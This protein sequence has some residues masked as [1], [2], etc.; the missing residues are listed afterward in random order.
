MIAGAS[1]IWTGILSSLKNDG[2]MVRSIPLACQNHPSVV[3]NAKSYQDFERTPNGGCMLKCGTRLDC[4]HA[5]DRKC[6]PV[7]PE[8]K[9]YVCMKPCVRIV[10]SSQHQCT[11]RCHEPCGNCEVVV[12]RTLPKCGHMKM[13][14]CYIPADE[15]SCTEPCP[16]LFEPCGHSC[17]K[18]CSE[19]CDKC[20]I[21]V[22]KVIP[23]CQH[24]CEIPCHLSPREFICRLP[25]KKAIGNCEH[26]CR[27]KC[28]EPCEEKCMALVPD[29]PWPCGHL[30]TKP[31]WNNP[32]NF[33]C[34][35][36]V[37]KTLSCG[38]SATLR[39]SDKPS[40]FQCR[41]AVC[42]RAIYVNIG[43]VCAPW[44]GCGL[45]SANLRVSIPYT[46]SRR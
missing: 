36:L 39:C 22:S 6:H 17:P 5:C 4:G 14:K 1:G 8:H 44:C 45:R 19:K 28:G 38:H 12:A 34:G 18:K 40:S 24:E 42:P 3:T 10:C 23:R 25:C 46:G 21:L 27:N 15:I 37:Q 13:T 32:S 7:D 9:N 30:L 20:E 43:N 2:K 35:E 41:T 11:K 31:C 33:P 26:V 29:R 16:H